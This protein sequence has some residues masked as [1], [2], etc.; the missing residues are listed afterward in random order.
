MCLPLPLARRP[1]S[2]KLSAHLTNDVDQWSQQR[3]PQPAIPQL[4]KDLPV[5]LGRLRGELYQIGSHLRQA[6]ALAQLRNAFD[7]FL[8]FAEHV[9]AV[10][11]ARSTELRTAARQALRRISEAQSTVL[12]DLEPAERFMSVLGTLLEQ[13]RVRLVEKGT[14]PRS[15]EVEAVGWFDENYAFLLPEAARRRVATFLRESGEAWG[16]SAHALRK[17]LVRKGFVLPGP[18]N[19]PEMQVR[20]GDG[21][22]RVLRV[23]L[24]ALRGVQ[25]PDPV[26]RWSPT[27]AKTGDA[28]DPPE[29]MEDQADTEVMSPSSPMSP[30]SEGRYPWDE[31]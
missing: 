19:R 17:A 27:S 11:A 20:V 26:P 6:D 4:Q 16:H 25:V 24:T 28:P 29:A 5:R 13:R 15:D 23:R 8:E 12:R 9:G 2:L 30:R 18:D 21:K 7:L 1:R 14:S 10:D 22:R 3:R 31:N